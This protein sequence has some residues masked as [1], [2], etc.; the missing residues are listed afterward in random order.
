M[1]LKI[2]CGS[3]L[4]MR[5]SLSNNK[6]RPH[7][8]NKL[9]PSSLYVKTD[10]LFKRFAYMQQVYDFMFVEISKDKTN[11]NATKR[12]VSGFLSVNL[13]MNNICIYCIYASIEF[14]KVK[15]MKRNLI[16]NWRFTKT[17]VLSYEYLQTFKRSF[18][19]TNY[20]TNYD[21]S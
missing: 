16:L 1:W 18:Y 11:F 14:K 17:F 10:M 2:W 21:N 13:L 6:R 5:I 15:I 8:N 20:D 7:T 12:L 3:N 19:D 9:E 4:P